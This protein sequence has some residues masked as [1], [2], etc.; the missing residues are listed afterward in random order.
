MITTPSNTCSCTN[1]WIHLQAMA[2]VHSAGHQ[3][4]SSADPG[5]GRTLSQNGWGHWN[6]WGWKVTVT[7]LWYSSEWVARQLCRVRSHWRGSCSWDTDRWQVCNAPPTH[8]HAQYHDQFLTSHPH[9]THT[10]T[11]QASQPTLHSNSSLT[12]VA[13]DQREQCGRYITEGNQHTPH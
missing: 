2:T 7:G 11:L 3:C 8:E 10:H 6:G 1:N 4:L 5:R 12:Q 13:G 9:T